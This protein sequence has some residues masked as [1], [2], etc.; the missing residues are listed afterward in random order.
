[1]FLAYLLRLLEV[2]STGGDPLDVFKCG[3]NN[4]GSSKIIPE[5][6]SD[7][8]EG[9]DSDVAAERQHVDRLEDESTEEVG[10]RFSLLI[11]AQNSNNSF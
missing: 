5:D 8:I 6:N 9:E 4:M 10:A 3:T 1:M 2:R 7:V 11:Q